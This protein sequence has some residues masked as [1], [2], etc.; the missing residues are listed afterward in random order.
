MPQLLLCLRSSRDPAQGGSALSPVAGGY[1]SLQ[2]SQK[3]LQSTPTQKREVAGA[4]NLPTI[5]EEEAP[6]PSINNLNF[7]ET[8]VTLAV[9]DGNVEAVSKLIAEGVNVNECNKNLYYPLA[10]A[11]Q[12]G[13]AGIVINLTPKLGAETYPSATAS[14]ALSDVNQVVE[15]PGPVATGA[16]PAGGEDNGGLAKTTGGSGGHGPVADGRALEASARAP[17]TNILPSPNPSG[18]A[19]TETSNAS[20]LAQGS[21]QT[22]NP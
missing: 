17:I 3:A 6:S 20:L 5:Q 11:T 4:R 13:H 14:G 1:S 16:A 9:L 7:D 21:G 8:K 19:H 15:A 10:L 18:S 22:P 12:N 2:G